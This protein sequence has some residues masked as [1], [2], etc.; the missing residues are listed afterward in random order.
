MHLRSVI[1]RIKQTT[2]WK[3]LNFDHVYQYDWQKVRWICEMYYEKVGCACGATKTLSENGYKWCYQRR[4]KFIDCEC[5]P[6]AQTDCY[7][8]VLPLRYIEFG[9]LNPTS[10][11]WYRD[12]KLLNVHE[13]PNWEDGPGIK[14]KIDKQKHELVQLSRWRVPDRFY[15]NRGVVLSSVEVGVFLKNWAPGGFEH[16]YKKLEVHDDVAHKTVG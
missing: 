9:F 12:T 15:S 6:L 8:E 11:Q 10:L 16:S 2:E 14:T 3:N 5:D 4:I 1:D 13:H 7:V